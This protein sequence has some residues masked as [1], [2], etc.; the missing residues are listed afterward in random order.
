MFN[1]K[2]IN[3]YIN[4]I[5]ILGINIEQLI[6]FADLLDK[7]YKLDSRD[8][9][10]SMSNENPSYVTDAH[11]NNYA[12]TVNDFVKNDVESRKQSQREN[13]ENGYCFYKDSPDKDTC[14]S[15]TEEGG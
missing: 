2:F 10:L 13:L 11:I 5:V 3:Y 9:H 1:N 15:F 7:D 12:Q 8:V 4:N 6:I 14:I